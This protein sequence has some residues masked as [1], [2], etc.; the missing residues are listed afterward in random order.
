MQMQEQEEG[1]GTLDISGLDMMMR[2]I[3]VTPIVSEDN[4]IKVV[5][6]N[7][8]PLVKECQVRE[9][10]R[11]KYG[12]EGKE[13]DTT[14]DELNREKAEIRKLARDYIHY[15]FCK[16]FAIKGVKDVK[17][18]KDIQKYWAENRRRDDGVNV[19][20]YAL[21]GYFDERKNWEILLERKFWQ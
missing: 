15:F 14:I 5:D 21:Y 17:T 4:V 16:A 2:P 19:M 20:K 10:V 8:L 18:M 1:E 13:L 11:I 7:Y 3:N 6:R 12:V 9:W